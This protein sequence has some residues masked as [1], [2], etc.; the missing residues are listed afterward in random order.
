MYHY[1]YPA[2]KLTPGTFTFTKGNK[3]EHSSL[4][5]LL[6]RLT[7]RLSYPSAHCL[8]FKAAQQFQWPDPIATLGFHERRDADYVR[9]HLWYSV[10]HRRLDDRVKSSSLLR[11]LIRAML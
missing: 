11:S 6:A 1:L 3:H 2:D 10:V 9:F 8:W 4:S 7:E 5:S